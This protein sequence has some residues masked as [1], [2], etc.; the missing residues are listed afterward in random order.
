M[1]QVNGEKLMNEMNGFLNDAAKE[2]SES[3]I[4]LP[5]EAF[6]DYST[7]PVSFNDQSK[8]MLQKVDAVFDLAVK[9]NRRSSQ[10]L[11]ACGQLEQGIKYLASGCVTKVA[12]EA[13]KHELPDLG[14]LSTEK[15]F[16]MISYHYRKIDRALSD[17]IREKN[18]EVDDALLDMEFRL[19][20]LLNRLRSTEVKIHDYNN[21]RYR[22]EEDY[23]PV[24]GGLAFTEKSW[25]R[26]FNEDHIEPASFQ[27]ARA[28]SPISEIGNQKSE[29]G[30]ENEEG[31][32]KKEELTVAGGQ[33]S[34]K[35]EIRNQ[36]SEI[37]S[38]NEEGS[39][40]NEENE[41]SND[42][43]H[44]SHLTPNCSEAA[45][46]SH[47]TPNCSEAA[48]SSLQTPHCSEAADAS[49]KT[50]DTSEAEIKHITEYSSYLDIMKNAAMRAPRDYEH[51]DQIAYSFT[52]EEMIQLA[53]DEE[54]A[55]V[56]PDMAAEIRAEVVK[57]Y[58]SG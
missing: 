36:K 5:F 27:R 26:S 57:M 9:Y 35:S 16:R 23:S 22:G 50:T 30:T 37:G 44:S 4:A 45:N 24:I 7:D 46:S 41:V 11:K 48:D 8:L 10:Y 17:Y 6:E 3:E 32:M 55:E 18:G 19:Y 54:F 12:L 49:L 39:L 20:N 42:T 40:K 31:R 38:V 1:T 13:K 34:A 56:F 51:P 33:Y 14:Q 47:L 52:T 15:L 21:K 25:N 53:R 2:N 28:F 29:I 43:S 58:G